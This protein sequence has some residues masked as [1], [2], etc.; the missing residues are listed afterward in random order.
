V[1]LSVSEVMFQVIAPVFEEIVALIV[2]LPASAPGLDDGFDGRFGQFVG[3]GNAVV[4]ELLPGIFTDDKQ[5][6]PVDE[7]R[8]LTRPEGN[9]IDVTIG[10]DFSKAPLPV[11]PGQTG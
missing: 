6:S 5:L 1:L 3:G 4:I 9:F 10:P 11:S 7:Q 8:S 2:D